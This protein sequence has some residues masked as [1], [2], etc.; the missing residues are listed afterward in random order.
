MLIAERDDG[1]RAQIVSRTALHYADGAD[2]ALDRPAFVRAASGIA[3]VGER[4]VIAQDDTAFVGVRDSDGRVVGVA[5]P[6]RPDGRRRFEARLGNKADKLD[7]EACVGLP[8]GRALLFGSGSTERRQR[9]VTFDSGALRVVDADELYAALRRERAFSGAELNV[10]GAAL[11]GTRLRLF[12]RGNGAATS[13]AAAVNATVDLDLRAFVA[14]LD[15]GAL[16][17]PPPL[18]NILRYDLGEVSGVPYG[19]TDASAFEGGAIYLAGAE[20][21]PNTY[22]DG[23]VL[24]AR[25]GIANERGVRFTDLLREDGSPAIEK[26]E[27]VLPWPERSDRAW[28]VIDPDDPDRPAELCEVAL[29]GPWGRYSV[30]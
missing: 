25:V 17:S 18:T 27:G 20:A 4:L 5:L 8:D 15:E 19:F 6:A 23:E 24:G 13:D 11:V 12:Q 3:R 14:W 7:L 16:G 21:S 26:A 10:E 9:I 1:L 30:P 2:D 22:D 28:V 29:E